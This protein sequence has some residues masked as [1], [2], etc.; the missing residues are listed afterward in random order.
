MDNRY[1]MGPSYWV[2]N[3]LHLSGSDEDSGNEVV[4]HPI[5]NEYQGDEMRMTGQ[6][7]VSMKIVKLSTIRPSAYLKIIPFMIH[8]SL[9]SIKT[10]M[11]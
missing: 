1:F 10:M 5:Y 11:S 7:L 2:H 4:D 6:T 9:I 8:R 3:P